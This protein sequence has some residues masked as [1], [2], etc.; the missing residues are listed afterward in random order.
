LR[1][2]PQ[3]ETNLQWRKL[4]RMLSV[5]EV[6]INR[7]LVEIMR[8]C[9]LNRQLDRGLKWFFHI[10]PFLHVLIHVHTKMIVPKWPGLFMTIPEPHISEFHVRQIMNNIFSFIKVF[11]LCTVDL[12]GFLFSVYCIIHGTSPIYKL[13]MFSK[14]CGT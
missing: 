8:K 3:F 5:W 12:L 13:C 14:I 4:L 7:N 9:F 2:I 11:V 10:L 1:V 6:D